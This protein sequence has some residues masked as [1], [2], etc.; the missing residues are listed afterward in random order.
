[1]VVLKTEVKIAVGLLLGAWAAVSHAA[2]PLSP[3]VVDKLAFQTGGLFLYAGGWPNPNSCT[4][5][6]AV[7]LADND[8]NYE[9]VYALILTA[10]ASGKKVSGYSVGC[11]SFDGQTYNPI[12]GWKYLV[13][14]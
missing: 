8:L 12:R 7:V 4:R 6:N 14:E 11:I 5:S 13:I 3:N 10:Y 9:K 2:G 1:M